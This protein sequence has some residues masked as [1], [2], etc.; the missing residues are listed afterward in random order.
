MPWVKER[1]SGP[2]KYL[3]RFCA[4]WP[5]AV[6]IDD[7]GCGLWATT[8]AGHYGSPIGSSFWDAAEWHVESA[9]SLSASAEAV[10]A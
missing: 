6:N 9:P 1:P 8:A 4:G 5:F 2:G 10:R 3:A 7:D